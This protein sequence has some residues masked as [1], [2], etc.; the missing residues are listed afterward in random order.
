MDRSILRIISKKKFRDYYLS[1]SQ[2][3]IPLTEWCYK[4]LET[5]APIFLY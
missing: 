4:I 5:K 2:S 3:E 1:N